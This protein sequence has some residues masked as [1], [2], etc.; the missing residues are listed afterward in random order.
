MAAG[1]GGGRENIHGSGGGAEAWSGQQRG[2]RAAVDVLR[3]CL[4]GGFEVALAGWWSWLRWQLEGGVAS[5]DDDN[6]SDGDGTIIVVRLECSV[7]V[8]HPK[9]GN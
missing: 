9:E 4:G 1:G 2:G 6:D 3:H 5:I 7:G 8:W